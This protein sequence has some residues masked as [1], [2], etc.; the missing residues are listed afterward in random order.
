VHRPIIKIDGEY[1]CVIAPDAALF[2]ARCARTSSITRHFLSSGPRR[3]TP[4][5]CSTFR[6]R[7]ARSASLYRGKVIG[8]EVS[9]PP[10]VE[11]NIGLLHQWCRH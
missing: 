4:R 11:K 10:T 6:A 2:F 5:R 7:L 8:R 1:E 3:A 9:M